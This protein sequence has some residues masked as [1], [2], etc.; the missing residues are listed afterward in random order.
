MSKNIPGHNTWL[1]SSRKLEFGDFDLEFEE[2]FFWLHL[3]KS[4]EIPTDIWILL[5]SV[6]QLSIQNSLFPRIELVGGTSNIWQGEDNL[7]NSIR[8]VC[9]CCRVAVCVGCRVAVDREMRSA[10]RLQGCRE[11]WAGGKNSPTLQVAH[12]HFHLNRLH[13]FNN[14]ALFHLQVCQRVSLPRMWATKMMTL[15]RFARVWTI[16]KVMG[17]VDPIHHLGNIHLSSA[18]MPLT[19]SSCFQRK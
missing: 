3:L 7:G 4:R 13:Q 16:L 10:G 17:T 8:Q 1:H 2:I 19:P 18:Y 14:S 12:D 9:V 15:G 6:L 5:H 11:R